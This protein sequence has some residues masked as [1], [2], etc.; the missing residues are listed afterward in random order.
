MR[1]SLNELET[2]YARAFEA[3]GLAAGLAA[4]A[5]R[6]AARHDVW[7]LDG[8]AAVTDR[9]HRLDGAPLVEPS[10]DRGQAAAMLDAR[11]ASLLQVGAP[12]LD[13]LEIEAARDAGGRLH[14]TNCADAD[15]APGLAALA[16][17]RGLTT[18]LRARVG[19]ELLT[20]AV[21]GGETAL[22]RGPAE[23]GTAPA[24][25]A[26]EL[27][28]GAAVGD[29]LPDADRATVALTGNLLRARERD[30]VDLGVAVD[31]ERWRRIYAL[32][33]RFLVSETEESRR[34]GAGGGSDRD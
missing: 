21:C 31:A 19:E 6:M 24:P 4:D 20:A 27:T 29:R 10:V 33:A 32:G 14:L 2:R 9:L 22:Y 12:A 26:L 28:A 1:V 7:G 17:A 15:F 8:L 18:V 25:D 3:M 11:G 13:L 34:R 23:A 5:A 16:A 30:A